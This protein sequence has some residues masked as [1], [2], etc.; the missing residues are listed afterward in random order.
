MKRVF[1][2]LLL[3]AWTCA[4]PALAEEERFDEA[5]LARML[6]PIALYPDSLLAQ[7]LVASTYPLEVVE[8]AR[9]SRDN[10]KLA[11]SEAV[12]AVADR[13]WDPSVRALTAF[14][15]LLAR[16][17][18]D[19][20]W[21]RD[22]GDAFLLQEEEVLDTIQ[23]LRRQAYE[24]GSLDSPEHIRVFRDGDRIVIEPAE[25]RVVY[26]PYYS[27]RIVYG[28]WLWYSR[29]PVYW[30]PPP[31]HLTRTRIVWVGGRHLP[32]S[33][34]LTTCDWH[35]RH[36]VVIHHPSPSL[37]ERAV[38]RT[39]EVHPSQRWRHDPI[40]RR[41]VR[42]RSDVLERKF[43]HPPPREVVRQEDV[44]SSRRTYIGYE[45]LRDRLGSD[46][47]VREPR[48]SLR[49]PPAYERAHSFRLREETRGET[50]TIRPRVND[51]TFRLGTD[52]RERAQVE[53]SEDR[54]TRPDW[55][56][57][58]SPDGDNRATRLRRER[59][60]RSD[61]RASTRERRAV[62]PGDDNRGF[63]SRSGSIR[64]PGERDRPDTDRSSRI[65]RETRR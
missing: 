27:P 3:L 46:G 37:R 36:I 64:G 62:R 42:Y 9:W 8:A 4:P 32:H 55:R 20:S 39:R 45:Q 17:S 51:R 47:T 24:H 43:G 29:P 61:P 22:L 48:S 6:A 57:L 52:P 35:R 65:R 34:F 54:R 53:R 2:P 5:E 41:G 38:H 50:R 30:R 25:P 14:P 31:G 16:M 11:G 18:D 23:E 26:V 19:L 56:S 28:G 60:D 12:E 59:E 58:R 63:G 49:R 13:D 1:V 15:D 7:V 10:P 21:T 33:F 40:H 44:T